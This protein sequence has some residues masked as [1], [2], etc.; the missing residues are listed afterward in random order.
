MGLCGADIRFPS[1]ELDNDCPVVDW[2]IRTGAD[3]DCDLIRKGSV[4]MNIEEANRWFCL[5][6]GE[7]TVFEREWHHADL[8]YN[9]VKWWNSH[10][11]RCSR[12]I[13]KIGWDGEPPP[14]T[15]TPI[16]EDP[17]KQGWDALE[18]EFDK[19][20]KELDEEEQ[21]LEEGEER[22]ELERIEKELDEE[23]QN[24]EDGEEGEEDGDEDDEDGDEDEDEDEE[25]LSKESS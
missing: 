16:A 4:G 21:N 3:K 2:R 14:H 22:E 24:L 10:K 6:E 23:E 1:N 18:E 12:T 25:D 17:N 19:I 15:L 5:N 9:P 8:T 13:F 11:Y 7:H 20:R